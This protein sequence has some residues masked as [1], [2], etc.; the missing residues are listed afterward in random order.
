MPGADNMHQHPN[1]KH[2]NPEQ[3]T[4]QKRRQKNEGGKRQNTQQAA[5]EKESEGKPEIVEKFVERLERNG[6]CDPSSS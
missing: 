6:V 4:R 2:M 5:L 3:Q 1:P